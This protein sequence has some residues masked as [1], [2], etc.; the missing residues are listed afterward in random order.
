MEKLYSFDCYKASDCGKWGKAFERA[1]KEHFGQCDK[2]SKQGAVDSRRHG[3]CFEDK[4]GAGEL[5]FLYRS[6]VKYVKYVPVVAENVA[7]CYQEGFIFERE[8]FL[9]MLADVGLIREKISTAGQHKIT[10]QTFWNHSKNK[11]HGKK[12]FDLLDAC[13]ERCIMTLEEYYEAGGDF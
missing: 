4:T 3:K 10:I 7:V 1:N 5:D 9:Q 6:K 12:Y 2:V 11:P 8:T 13:Y